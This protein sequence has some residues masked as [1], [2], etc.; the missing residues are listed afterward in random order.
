MYQYIQA[1]KHLNTNI[2]HTLD[3]KTKKRA[4]S[5]PYSKLTGNLETRGGLGGKDTGCSVVHGQAR[6]F[7]RVEQQIADGWTDV[8]EIS[9]TC[10]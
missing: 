3:S 6:L 4:D 1:H 9:G 8:P 10:R 7:P 2:P 5:S